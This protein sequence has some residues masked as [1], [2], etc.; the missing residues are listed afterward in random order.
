MVKENYKPEKSGIFYILLYT[1]TV[2]KDEH[3]HREVVRCHVPCS[4]NA[5]TFLSL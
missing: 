1:K 2:E 3:S 5:R 4:G